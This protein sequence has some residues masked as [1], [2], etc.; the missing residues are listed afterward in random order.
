MGDWR[1]RGRSRRSRD[2]GPRRRCD[3]P[4]RRRRGCAENAMRPE[5]KNCQRRAVD[6]TGRRQTVLD[7]EPPDRRTGPR[8]EHAVD[9]PGAVPECVEAA[10]DIANSVRASA[11][12][13]ACALPD[14][15]RGGGL[16]Q[17]D[18]RAVRPLDRA[19]A[20][21]RVGNQIRRPCGR[22]RFEARRI[23]QG[24]RSEPQDASGCGRHDQR[25][26]ASAGLHACEEHGGYVPPGLPN[27]PWFRR[28]TS[29]VSPPCKR[30]IAP[31]RE[32]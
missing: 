16:G 30:D 14:H 8:S 20:P 24:G 15:G 9:G 28:A 7:L 23:R 3:W 26:G 10:L 29:L 18:R 5:A 25:G 19:A 11:I 32:G 4:L 2:F 13:E 27:R 31:L 17:L 6:C 22:L 21:G 12:P 1:A